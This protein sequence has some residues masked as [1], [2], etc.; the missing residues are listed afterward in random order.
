MTRPLT[1][2]AEAGVNH[3]GDVHKAIAL[4]RAARKAGADIVKFQYFQTDT[5]VAAGAKSAAYQQANTGI[6]DQSSLLRSLELSLEDYAR[7]AAAC[8]DEG[9]GFLCTSFDTNAIAALV[10]LGMPALKIPSGE[11][12]NH[13]MLKAYAGQGLPVWLS[14]GM[15]TLAE[16]GVALA[17]LDAAG[18]TDVTI[19]HCTSI[20]PAPVDALNL[21]A[22]GTLA[23]SFGRPVG[24]SDHSLDDHASVAAVALGA[25]LIEK[26]F[27][28]DCNS[29][30]PDHRASLE[31]AAFAQMVRRLR[32]TSAMLGDGVKR[33]VPAEMETARLVR[34]SWH[35]TRDL[36]AGDVISS[37]DIVLLRPAT[38]IAPSQGIEG[39]RLVRDVRVNSAI[40]T[41]DI[42]P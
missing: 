7:V 21:L 22:I 27:T 16:V 38:G 6:A 41:D 39:R 24:Y 42:A 18:A 2:I 33:P 8:R 31:P 36:R 9:I 15:G 19:L 23:Q 35:S 25:Q 37:R 12:T 4:V 34:R 5:I 32:E 11:L 3:D 20:Y 26:H 13:P 29:P 10:A 1:I 28:L 30:G 14:T 17:V 40:N